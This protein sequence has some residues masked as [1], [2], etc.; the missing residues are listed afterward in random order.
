[1]CR[2]VSCCVSGGDAGLGFIRRRSHVVC[3]IDMVLAF[4]HMGACICLPYR[5]EF[6]GP[7]VRPDFSPAGQCFFEL[8]VR[9]FSRRGAAVNSRWPLIA[10]G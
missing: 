4:C 3:L 5:N 6:T 9:A 8:R 7:V 10:A 1:M 2:A